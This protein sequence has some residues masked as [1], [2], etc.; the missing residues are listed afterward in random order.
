MP[1]VSV[2]SLLFSRM[3]QVHRT[4]SSASLLSSSSFSSSDTTPTL[5]DPHLR[6]DTAF[7]KREYLLA[8]IR[9]KDAIIESLLKQVCYLCIVFHH[10]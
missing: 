6:L 3:P 8:Q 2:S 7:S 4:S 5:P 9:Q 1:R 10:L